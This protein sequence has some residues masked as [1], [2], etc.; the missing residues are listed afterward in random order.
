MKTSILA[1]LLG[2]AISTMPLGAV[3][4]THNGMLLGEAVEIARYG[5]LNTPSSVRTVQTILRAHGLYRGQIDGIAGPL[6]L[7]GLE[8]AQ[9]QTAVHVLP[10]VRMDVRYVTQAPPTVRVAAMPPPHVMYRPAYG[11]IVMPAQGYGYP[12]LPVAPGWAGV[13]P[14]SKY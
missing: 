4:Q 7:A 5:G 10:V 12:V 13:S 1:V 2:A 8:Q 14:F 6:T 3:A 9:R 11:N